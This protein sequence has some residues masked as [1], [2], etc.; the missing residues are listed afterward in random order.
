MCDTPMKGFRVGITKNGKQLLKLASMDASYVSVRDDGVLTVIYNDDNNSSVYAREVRKIRDFE[1]VPCGRCL[2]CRLAKAAEWANRCMLELKYHDTACFVTLTYDDDHVKNGCYTDPD[3]GELSFSRT[4]VKRDLQKF[5][6]RL[7]KKYPERNIR[8]YACG[9]YGESTQRPHYHAIIFGWKPD[10]LIPWSR[11]EKG[12]PLYLS[13]ELYEIWQN[14]N[15]LVGDVNYATC[16]YVARY[17]TKKVYSTDSDEQYIMQGRIP[18]FTSMSLKPA[19]GRQWYEDNPWCIDRPIS[20]STPDRGITFNAP[21]YFQKLYDRDHSE[22]ITNHDLYKDVKH[23][24][25]MAERP[26]LKEKNN[27]RES[28]IGEKKE[29]E[30]QKINKSFKRNA[31]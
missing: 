22:E 21:R 3:T 15:V 6:K 31:L 17:V 24:I 10:D 20:I 8:Y 11:N 14:G 23:D 1:I 28:V 4:L 29:A 19:I 5:W 12:D 7:R 2:A 30:R 25:M 18:P 13:K 16:N 9:E 26:Y 27:Q